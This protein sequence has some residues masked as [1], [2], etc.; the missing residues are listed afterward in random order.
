[1]P[2]TTSLRYE[3][4]YNKTPKTSTHVLTNLENRQWSCGVLQL[5]CRMRPFQDLVLG[6]TGF[7]REEE[8]DMEKTAR[9]NGGKILQ[10]TGLN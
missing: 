2:P 4:L 1:M 5:D 9:E 6:F 7:S 10:K 8:T 3:T